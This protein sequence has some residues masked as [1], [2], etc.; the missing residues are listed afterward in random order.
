MLAPDGMRSSL[1]HGAWSASRA[2]LSAGL[3]GKETAQVVLGA[4]QSVSTAGWGPSVCSPTFPSCTPH[5]RRS[6]VP[7][8]TV[9]L[10][11]GTSRLL[12]AT[13]L[14]LDTGAPIQLV[15]G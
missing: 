12:M 6:V 9:A 5:S 4:A 13:G 3:S 14:A 10:G 8:G 11:A 7:A 1:K 15:R 2:S